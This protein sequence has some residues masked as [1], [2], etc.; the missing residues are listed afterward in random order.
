MPLLLLSNT[1]SDPTAIADVE[2]AE[3]TN[4]ESDID[5]SLLSRVPAQEQQGHLD[6]AERIVCIGTGIFN[7]V[8]YLIGSNISG[9]YYYLS[10]TW[11]L[12]TNT[13][14]ASVAIQYANKVYLVPKPGSGNGGKWDPSGGFTAVAAI[15][16][17][18]A[19][20]V[21]KERLFVCPGID[22]TTNTSRLIFSNANN[23]D[24][25]TG[26][27]FID[28]GQG[29]GTKLI[30]LTVFQDNLLLFKDQSTYLLSY[31]IRPADATLRQISNTIGV[32]KQ[33]CLVNYENQVY[34]FHG[35]WVYEIINLDFNR[36][37]TKVP[38]IR[39][40]TVPSAFS[41]EN[42]FISIIEDKLFCRYYRKVYVY[43]LRTRTWSEWE[44][45]SENIQFF[46]PVTT[47]RPSTG[48][49]YYAGSCITD[50][51]SVIKLIRIHTS[52]D[53]EHAYNTVVTSSDDFNETVVDGWGNT[54]QGI[55]WTNSGGAAG[56]YDKTGTEGTHTHT[57]RNVFRGS[58]LTLGL[59]DVDEKVFVKIPVLPTGANFIFDLVARRD[60]GTD[61]MYLAR[62]TFQVAGTI[63]IAILKRIAGV[64][65]LLGF[66]DTGI[67]TAINTYYGFRFNIQGTQLKTRTWLAS[68]SEPITWNQAYT[69]TSITVSGDIGLRSILETATTNVLPVAFTMDNWQAISLASTEYD[70]E[71]SIK[72]KNFDMAVSHQF[73]RLWWWGADLS[74]PNDIV[75]MATPVILSFGV[76]WSQ[77]HAFT[78]GQLHSN[79]WGQPLSEPLTVTT[80]ITGQGGLSRRFAKFMKSLRYRQINFKIILVTNGS[81]SDGPARIFT[82]TAV[83]ETK[84]VV[85][86][87]VN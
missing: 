45:N 56:D 34:V 65:T 31:D 62:I 77:L 42:I 23:F 39:D 66:V 35:G 13:F 54:D 7:D 75:G 69:D 1:A 33:H 74:T 48:N 79:T 52:T 14:Q 55:A 80:T 11:T 16:K 10:G 68:G 25:W 46:G 82:V 85:P 81:T 12:I 41:S 30:D 86:K 15:P 9:V 22:S 84:A 21:Y 37:N 71:C 49:E 26:T 4:F 17:G 18:Q 47:I 44:S 59:T 3:L 83:T 53:T 8:H 58:F 40:E 63:S 29:D 6:W 43:G 51:R 32:T 19:A 27:D 70:I 24:T 28:I 36:L 38:F 87:A 78:W 50:K 2:L 57:S 67:T 76:T 73:K 5:G 72:T 20:V 64:Q 61:T 60:G